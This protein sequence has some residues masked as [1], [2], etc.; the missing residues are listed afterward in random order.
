M[1]TNFAV[2]AAWAAMQL[3]A[4]LILLWFG[5]QHGIGQS[6]YL[7]S[8]AVIALLAVLA[9][10]RSI[11]G[12]SFRDVLLSAA[13]A[14]ALFCMLFLTITPMVF[15]GAVKGWVWGEVPATGTLVLLALVCAGN[16][17]V[18]LAASVVSSLRRKP[19]HTPG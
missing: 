19:S 5:S 12:R 18:G 2:G 4:V 11:K 10:A 16:V 8:I 3:S 14:S 9:L 6:G 17:G 15:P 1:K 13:V 7:V